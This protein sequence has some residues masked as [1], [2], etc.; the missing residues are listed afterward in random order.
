MSE[1]AKKAHMY[2]CTDI[3]EPSCEL[4][5]CQRYKPYH[6]LSGSEPVR[7][8]TEPPDMTRNPF[9]H[10]TVIDLDKIFTATRS[11]FPDSLKTTQ[12]VCDALFAEIRLNLRT[13]TVRVALT[14]AELR[15]VNP[16][17]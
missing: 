15:S 12:G 5:K 9:R 17:I 8:I 1:L 4:V 7:R 11:L 16:K 6:T 3:P 14:D 13:D 10:P 2:I